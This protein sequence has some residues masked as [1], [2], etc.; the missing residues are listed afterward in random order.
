MNHEQRDRSYW[1]EYRERKAKNYKLTV[2]KYAAEKGISPTVMTGYLR[3]ARDGLIAEIARVRAEQQA[4][5]D[6]PGLPGSGASDQTGAR[7]PV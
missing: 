1:L 7:S 4:K 6:A 5:G 2:A 3:R